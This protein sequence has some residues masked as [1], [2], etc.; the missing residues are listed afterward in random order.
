MF[1]TFF[2]RFG[3][4]DKI[5]S[6]S[7]SQFVNIVIQRVFQYLWIK[8]RLRCVYHLQSQGMVESPNGSLKAK[9]AKICEAGKMN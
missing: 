2:V 6:D 9:L 8:H 1:C 5:G 7:G 4:P 3:I